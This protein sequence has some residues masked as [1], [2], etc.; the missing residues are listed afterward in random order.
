MCIRDR[1][2]TEQETKTNHTPAHPSILHP[3]DNTSIHE[4]CTYENARSETEST[5]SQ[6]PTCCKASMTVI[7]GDPP[8]GLGVMTLATAVVPGLSLCDAMPQK[9][10]KKHRCW[11]KKSIRS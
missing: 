6:Q 3:S 11:N 2:T 5:A 7:D 8:S 10:G 1:E 4:L 9:E